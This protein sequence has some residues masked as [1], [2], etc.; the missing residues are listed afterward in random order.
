MNIPENVLIDECDR[1]MLE[2][3]GIW[4]VNTLGY[5]CR[6]EYPSNSKIYMHRIIMRPPEDMVVDHI[7]HNRHDN[8]RCNLRIVTKQQNHW[9]QSGI[10]GY[11][12]KGNKFEVSIKVNNKNIYIG[13]FNS[14]SEAYQ[15]YLDAKQELH[16]I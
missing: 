5:C 14:E 2:G 13:S 15:S 7:N 1:A 16:K 3:F 6:S 8:R 10:K 11:R 12:K 9:N 4:H